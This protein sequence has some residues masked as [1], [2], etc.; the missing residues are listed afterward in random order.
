MRDFAGMTVD[1]ILTAIDEDLPHWEVLMRTNHH[2][3]VASG[4]C[5]GED[6][7]VMGPARFF[8]NLSL[9]D[10][11]PTVLFHRGRQVG[12]RISGVS[13]KAYGPTLRDCLQSCYNRAV[14]LKTAEGGEQ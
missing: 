10:G 12:G 11:P 3:V 9:T 2:M 8:V 5:F 6:T 7:V 14:L 1:D 13:M 4:R